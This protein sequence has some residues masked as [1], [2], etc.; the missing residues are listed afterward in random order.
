MKVITI[1]LVVTFALSLLIC[2]TNAQ[3]PQSTKQSEKTTGVSSGKLN[4]SPTIDI[5]RQ[6][7]RYLVRGFADRI[8]GVRDQNLR[9][10]ALGQLADL[11]W[12]DD[13]IF[14]RQMFTKALDAVSAKSEA[15]SVLAPATN[16]GTANIRKTLIAQIAK[17]DIDWANKLADQQETSGEGTDSAQSNIEIA[18]DLALN[19]KLDESVAFVKRSLRG[20]VSWWLCGV[21]KELREKDQKTADLLFIKSMSQL[22]GQS[23]VDANL[24]LYLGSYVFTSPYANQDD[25]TSTTQV[26]IDRYMVY[27]L[28]MDR[29]NV[30]PFVIRA[31]LSAA[32][33]ILSR[34]IKD[35]T[36]QALYYI[37]GRMLLPKAER[38]APELVEQLAFGMQARIGDIRPSLTQEAAYRDLQ[39]PKQKEL[40][41]ALSDIEK[42]PDADTRDAKYLSVISGLWRKGDYKN[43]RIVNAKI[44]D[45][46]R[47][48]AVATLVDFGEGRRALDDNNLTQAEELAAKL[49]QGIEKAVLL[50]GLGKKLAQLGDFVKASSTLGRA[51]SA[52]GY[53]NDARTPF[54]ILNTGGIFA[55]FDPVRSSAVLM[56]A[57]KELNKYSDAS[58]QRIEWQVKVEAP[59]MWR[60]FPLEMK[61]IEFGYRQPFASLVKI[62]TQRAIDSVSTLSSEKQQADAF[63]AIATALL[64]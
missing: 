14:A 37:A 42:F 4:K 27:E 22:A 57:I 26:G 16:A 51:I 3:I 19:G 53:V 12:R 56:E 10:T 30:S 2:R 39:P 8:A 34:Q 44:V 28:T 45:D 54:V 7:S 18:Q 35:P 41:D 1:K 32:V 50:L 36:Q 55:S 25:Y 64:K 21:L 6:Q 60:Y 15:A 61:G 11:I 33:A 46:S 17:H 43:A 5:Q 48:R 58:F 38:Y 13:E 63:I 40:A 23:E 29:S 20:G 9:A 59:P 31:Y 49:P 24:L 47:R 62:D 52:A